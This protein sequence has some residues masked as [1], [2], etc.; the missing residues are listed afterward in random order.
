MTHE[1]R[2]NGMM[3]GSRGCT[4][5]GRM[6]QIGETAPN[7]QLVANDFSTKTLADYA[8]KVKILS[9]VPSLPTSVCSAQTR[10]FNQE[11]EALGSEVALLTISADLP[12]AQRAWC[13]AEGIKAVETLSTHRDMQFSDAYGVHNVDLRLNQRAVFVLD[14]EDKVV[15]AE[16]VLAI[17]DEVNFEAALDAARKA[18]G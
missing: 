3:L 16:Y 17:G 2:P 10:R 11:A 14:R 8:G 6:L 13:S 7:F 9:V 15:H 18:L 4:V 1:E 5:R 12:I